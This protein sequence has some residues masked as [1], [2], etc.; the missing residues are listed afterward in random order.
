MRPRA[1][2]GLSTPQNGVGLRTIIVFEHFMLNGVKSGLA[3]LCGGKGL[4]LS[5]I[6]LQ[7]I[8]LNI[9]ARVQEPAVAPP[10][11]PQLRQHEA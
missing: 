5:D 4:L 9:R 6:F 1:T 11:G 8:L 10:C 7:F 2:D 3:M